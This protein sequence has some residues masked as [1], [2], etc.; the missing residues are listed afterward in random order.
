MKYTWRDYWNEYPGFGEEWDLNH[1]RTFGTKNFRI[2]EFRC[3]CCNCIPPQGIAPEL[4]LALEELRWSL[5]KVPVRVVSGYRCPKYNAKV[6]GAK[7]SQHLKG[8]AADI[9]VK[10]F[11]P[12]YVAIEAGMVEQFYKGGIG[13]YNTFTHVDVRGCYCGKRARWTG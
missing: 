4:I 10:G 12:V 2:D 5:G 9:Q 1:V 13:L 8:T 3:K 7:N 6:C 11:K